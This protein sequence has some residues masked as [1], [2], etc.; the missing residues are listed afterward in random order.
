MARD[1]LRVRLGAHAY[2]IPASLL[3]TQLPTLPTRFLLL[4]ARVLRSPPRS[5]VRAPLSKQPNKVVPRHLL[6]YILLLASQ[7]GVLGSTEVREPPR[8]EVFLYRA[9]GPS[10]CWSRYLGHHTRFPSLSAF[11]PRCD[12]LHAFARASVVLP[13]PNPR[14]PPIELCYSIIRHHRS[15]SPV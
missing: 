2:A 1:L 9:A 4:V 10:S 12:R 8:K 15:H 11:R 14:P 5:T 6:V 13:F 3:E 7:P